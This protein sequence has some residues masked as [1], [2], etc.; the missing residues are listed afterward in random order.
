M[1]T[2]FLTA[3]LATT[4][5]QRGGPPPQQ[6]PP[7]GVGS[8]QGTVES[9]SSKIGIA[10]VQISVTFQPPVNRSSPVPQQGAFPA[11]Q[12]VATLQ[13]D[14]SVHFGLKNL[15]V[16]TYILQATREGYTA[17]ENQF[18]GAPR[19]ASIYATLVAADQTSNV[20]LTLTRG[21]TISG[22][23]IDAKGNSVPNITVGV[24]QKEYQDGRAV[25]LS[26][27]TKQTD[28]RGEYRLF[29]LNPGEYY[30]GILPGAGAGAFAARGGAEV[31]PGVP[32]PTF[33][34]GV[35]DAR[36]A[37]RIKVDEGAELTGVSFSQSVGPSGVRVTGIVDNSLPNIP[38][39]PRGQPPNLGARQFY[40]IPLDPSVLTQS[41][42]AA[43]QGGARGGSDTFFQISGVLPGS[44]DLIALVAD[45][46]GRPFPGRTRIDVGNQDLTGVTIPVHPGV[47]V[48]GHITLSGTGTAAVP[49]ELLRV[50]LRPADGTPATAAN[51]FLNA[52]ARG[53]R[54]QIG[55][56]TAP[57]D[58]SLFSYPNVPDGRYSIQLT[59]PASAY[60]EDIREGT[61]SIFDSGLTIENGNAP[62]EIQ[63]LINS[64]GERL[65]GTV[66]DTAQKAVVA[67]VVLVPAPSR[68]QNASLYKTAM[69]NATG[70]FTLSGVAPGDYKL[71][72]WEDVPNGAWQNAEFMTNYE[73]LGTAV[74]IAPGIRNDIQI[75]VIPAGQ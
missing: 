24:F 68:R 70:K 37:T 32:H 58:P 65:E 22:R 74:R 18:S 10:D 46:Q 6:Q 56:V 35:I 60:I 53:A 13:T 33:Y 67:R 40:L 42:T 29:W 44:Y 39:G 36:T 31:G 64:D 12:V 51:N 54:G 43:I 63:I 45:D 50:Q 52:G 72:A 55:G 7:T 61:R 71:F 25:L 75:R 47:E 4:L 1:R 9:R 57:A 48:K 3:V 62:G 19:P 38:A 15:A 73:V 17:G 69:S 28:D 16:G 8:I 20:T 66:L 34:P 30:I 21:A 11:Q 41:N 23:I 14:A 26:V 59:L 49:L 2:L 27:L 5:F